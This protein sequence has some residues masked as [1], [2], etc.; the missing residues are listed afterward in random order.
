MFDPG[1]PV[2]DT[3]DGRDV[4][5]FL[6]EAVG[7]QGV[8]RDLLLAQPQGEGGHPRAASAP[9]CPACPGREVGGTG[10]VGP[11]TPVHPLGDHVDGGQQH[12]ARIRVDRPPRLVPDRVRSARRDADEL[13]E[14]QFEDAVGQ[15]RA[16]DGVD[17][18][19]LGA[20]P[21]PVRLTDL[22]RVGVGGARR[23]RAVRPHP[24]EA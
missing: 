18:E 5:A 14:V 12:P 24:D 20:R 21:H 8:L 23:L 7:D 1:D 17:H 15:S 16:G 4:G 6:V 10:V 9:G 22:R 13:D 19:A 3:V 11:P 2:A